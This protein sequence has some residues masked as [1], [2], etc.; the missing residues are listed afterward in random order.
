MVFDFISSSFSLSLSFFTLEYAES[1][2]KLLNPL[3][4]HITEEIWTKILKHNHT[5][6]YEAWPSYDETKT[7]SDTYE[8]VVQVNGKIRGKIDVSMN[9]SKEEMENLAK[10]IPNVKSNLEGKQIVKIIIVPNKL[11]NIV[12]K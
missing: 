4:P 9:T 10:E 11:V 12:I 5:I 8:M 7:V 1:F 3:A 6:A 2:I